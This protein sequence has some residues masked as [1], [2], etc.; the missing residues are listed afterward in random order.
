VNLF[1]RVARSFGDT[2]ELLR[3]ITPRSTRGHGLVFLNRAAE[4]LADTSDAVRLARDLDTPEGQAYALWHR[5]EALSALGRPDEA[6]ADATEA[7][8]IARDAGHRG[9]TATAHRALGI[10]LQ[11][12][13]LLDEAAA[14]YARS[15]ELAGDDLTLFSSWAA[16]RGALVAIAQGRLDDADP[17]VRHALATGPAL[18]H[19]EARLAAVE[20][21]A[22]R[23]EPDYPRRAGDALTAA[24]AGGHQASATRLASL[25]TAAT[26]P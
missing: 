14:S 17:L 5:S 25:A 16:A 23:A 21:A 20:L 2:G 12:R 26:P 10:S 6:G 9:W 22:A 8:R 15:A 24:R 7:L 1:G 11:T 13:G 4:G 18:G 19:Y 3:I